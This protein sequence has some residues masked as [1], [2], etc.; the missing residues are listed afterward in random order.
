MT[1]VQDIEN[2][3]RNR[4]RYENAL[5]YGAVASIGT[6]VL[7]AAQAFMSSYVILD[8]AVSLGLATIVDAQM[9]RLKTRKKIQQSETHFVNEHGNSYEKIWVGNL[10]DQEKALR[11]K[12]RI[13]STVS[14]SSIVSAFIVTTAFVPQINSVMIPAFAVVGLLV[15][16]KATKKTS[17]ALNDSVAQRRTLVEQIHLR[18]TTEDHSIPSPHH[19]SPNKT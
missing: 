7:V 17:S 8:V 13:I 16:N 5:S 4:N 18:R 12:N 9:D 14:L 6:C 1:V 3:T 2:V 10:N 19:L 15:H 11:K